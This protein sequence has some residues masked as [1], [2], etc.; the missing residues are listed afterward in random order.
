MIDT[1]L[2]NYVSVYRERTCRSKVYS[3]FVDWLIY[4]FVVYLHVYYGAPY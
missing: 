2:V 4:L 3:T 1:L